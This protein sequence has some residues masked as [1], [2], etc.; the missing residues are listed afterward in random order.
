MVY[1]LYRFFLHALNNT[2]LKKNCKL[3]P[4]DL[5]KKEVSPTDCCSTASVPLQF[6]HNF[7]LTGVPSDDE[8]GVQVNS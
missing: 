2:N 6:A 3:I 7:Q 5:K 8:E 4:C 1:Y